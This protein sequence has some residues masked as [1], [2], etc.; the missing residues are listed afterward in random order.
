MLWQASL[1]DVDYMVPQIFVMIGS[2]KGVLCHW[3]QTIT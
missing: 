3:H 1:N 2:G